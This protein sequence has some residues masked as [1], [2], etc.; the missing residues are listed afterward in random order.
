[1]VPR[2]PPYVSRDDAPAKRQ[3][4][5]AAL[6]LF[7]EKGL[8]ETTIRDIAR[9]SGYTNPALFK[10]FDGKD[11][12][13]AYLFE[14]CYL[15]LFHAVAE[16]N[17]AGRTFAEKHRAVIHAYVTALDTDQ[18]AVLYVQD[19]LRHFWPAMPAHVRRHSILR[20]IRTLLEAGRS[21]RAVTASVDVALL[22]TAWVGTLQQ[23]ARARY[24]G[25]F[26]QPLTVLEPELRAL[27]MRMASPARSTVR[28]S[29]KSM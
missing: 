5:V 17:A 24:F 14:R 13:A 27:L 21:E 9:R 18:N 29:V 8:C 6:E 7:V 22:V 25:E 20:E 28:S 16:A 10:H 23:F 3:I 4:L 11:A 26:R 19:H 2:T 12:L 1:M 15:N